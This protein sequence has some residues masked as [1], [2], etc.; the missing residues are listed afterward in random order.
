M[1]KVIIEIP[2]ELGTIVYEVFDRC[3]ADMYHCPFNGGYGT[4]RCRNKEHDDLCKAYYKEVPFE[5]Y[6]N[7]RVGKDIFITEKEAKK[8]IDKQNKRQ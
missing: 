2:V 8:W 7:N 5:L 1:P 6:M 3:N 4:D